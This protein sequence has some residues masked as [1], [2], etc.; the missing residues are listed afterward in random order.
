LLG[1][2]AGVRF[3]FDDARAGDQEERIGAAEAERV[4]LDFVS[5]GHSE[6]GR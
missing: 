1:H 4:E 6:L 3:G 5:G 2:F